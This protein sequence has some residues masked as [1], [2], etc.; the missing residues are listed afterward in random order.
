MS[1]PWKNDQTTLEKIEETVLDFLDKLDIEEHVSDVVS[2][3]KEKIPGVTPAKKSHKKRNVLLL[4]LL[5]GGA[6]F[7]VASRNKTQQPP[8]EFAPA[9]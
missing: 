5:G 7:Y 3:V 1:A 2:D 4:V 9:I 8:A 6:A